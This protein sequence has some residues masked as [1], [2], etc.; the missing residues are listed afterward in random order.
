[1]F[2]KACFS[3]IFPRFFVGNE[4]PHNTPTLTHTFFDTSKADSFQSESTKSSLRTFNSNP[5]SYF[6]ATFSIPIYPINEFDTSIKS[7]SQNIEV[8]DNAYLSIYSEQG[9]QLSNRL[10]KKEELS[11]LCGIGELAISKL[12]YELKL[13]K[14]KFYSIKFSFVNEVNPSPN[15]LN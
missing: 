14:N 2:H 3:D 10:L 7:Y 1:M 15:V 12:T 4:S 6:D 13:K 9:E 5:N 11:T 8:K